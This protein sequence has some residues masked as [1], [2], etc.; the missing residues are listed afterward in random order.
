MSG[1]ERLS[2]ERCRRVGMSESLR[3]RRSEGMTQRILPP[4]SCQHLLSLEGVMA[5]EVPQ[6][7]EISGG[8]NDGGRKRIG[9]AILQRRTNRGSTNI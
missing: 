7:E 2:E 5:I 4:H 8:G 3:G 1:E 6:N 9:S